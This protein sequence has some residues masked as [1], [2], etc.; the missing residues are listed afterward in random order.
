MPRSFPQNDC[1]VALVVAV[2]GP[3]IPAWPA[4]VCKNHL[5]NTG[6]DSSPENCCIRRRLSRLASAAEHT[7]APQQNCQAAAVFV[8]VS[9]RPAGAVGP[10]LACKQ[11]APPTAAEAFSARDCWR[12]DGTVRG[13]GNITPLRT[14]GFL[15]T[16][17]SS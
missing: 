2:A 5:S 3:E 15:D 14:L 1:Q 11:E 17:A 9:A 6:R 4:L 13:D 8:L 16:R 7:G 10:T 12:E